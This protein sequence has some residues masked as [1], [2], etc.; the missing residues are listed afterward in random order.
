MFRPDP[1][2]IP[3]SEEGTKNLHKLADQFVQLEG[4]HELGRDERFYQVEV[5]FRRND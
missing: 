3:V 4:N 2:D 5:H 1:P